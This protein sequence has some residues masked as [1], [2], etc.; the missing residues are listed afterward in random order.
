MFV[1][2]LVIG[3]AIV[4]CIVMFIALVLL[5]QC[6]AIL[7]HRI[8][9]LN[10]DVMLLREDKHILEDKISKLKCGVAIFQA[11]NSPKG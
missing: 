10:C 6:V 2:E 11:E 1:S 9:R 3:I 5:M 7:E 4:V 8:S